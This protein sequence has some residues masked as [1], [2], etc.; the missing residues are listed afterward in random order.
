MANYNNN[1]R[2]KG[3]YFDQYVN[4]DQFLMQHNMNNWSASHGLPPSG[5]GFAP[6][7]AYASPSS[8]TFQTFNGGGSNQ[9]HGGAFYFHPQS[10]NA[11]TVFSPPL[12][13]LSSNLTATASEFIPQQTTNSALAATASEFIPRN[14]Q[15]NVKQH[16]IDSKPTTVS[17]AT[18]AAA[19]AASFSLASSVSCDKSKDDSSTNTES[20][21]QTLTNTHISDDKTLNSSGGAIKKVRSQDYRNDSRD[22]HSNG[23]FL[24]TNL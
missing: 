10:A 23:K 11:N 6:T 24:D 7:S 5:N 16:T 15:N 8:N 1:V 22:R 20:V 9:Y 13:P 14:Q 21:I 17:L 4:F 12:P 2:Q 3:G 19:A 18:A